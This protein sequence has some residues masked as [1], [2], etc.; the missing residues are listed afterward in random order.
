MKAQSPVMA[1]NFP[2]YVDLQPRHKM[3]STQPSPVADSPPVYGN[4]TFPRNQLEKV[5]IYMIIAS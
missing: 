1:E 4:H 5:R 3:K 2:D